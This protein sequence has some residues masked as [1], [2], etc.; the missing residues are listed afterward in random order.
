MSAQL[1]LIV[2]CIHVLAVQQSG[3]LP[4]KHTVNKCCCCT[5]DQ[6][7]SEKNSDYTCIVLVVKQCILCCTGIQ[8][9]VN[10]VEKK[11]IFLCFS[12]Y[13]FFINTIVV[14]DFFGKRS[15]R[16]PCHMTF[17]RYVYM[18]L[19]YHLAG[20]TWSIPCPCVFS[21]P[22]KLTSSH[23]KHF[24]TPAPL[25]VQNLDPELITDHSLFCIFRSTRIVRH[26]QKASRQGTLQSH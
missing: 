23:C 25:C 18:N 13:V 4:W 22:H 19:N 10:D 3:A 2:F 7:K 26:T 5:I 15:K 11:N 6:C 1:P 24:S 16:F 9:F 12:K 8:F 21:P 20:Q 17:L 14:C